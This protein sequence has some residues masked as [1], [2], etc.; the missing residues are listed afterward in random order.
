MSAPV[1]I[2]AGGGGELGCATAIA[3]A[4]DGRSVVA[5]DWSE[6]RLRDLPNGVRREVADPTDPP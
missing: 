1:A 6:R 5:V 3:L 4:A 2:V